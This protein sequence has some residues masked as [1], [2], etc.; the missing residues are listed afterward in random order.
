MW[1]ANEWALPMIV[2]RRLWDADGCGLMIVVMDRGSEGYG[3]VAVMEVSS[4][5]V[6][7]FFFFWFCLVLLGSDWAPIVRWSLVVNHGARV[8]AWIEGVVVRFG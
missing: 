2:L 7:F 8:G 5:S 6:F 1:F 3:L 4:F